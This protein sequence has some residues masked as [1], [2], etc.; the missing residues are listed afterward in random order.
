[1]SQLEE[2]NDDKFTI[3]KC[4]I[5]DDRILTAQGRTIC[6]TS[7]HIRALSQRIDEVVAEMQKLKMEL[8]GE[9]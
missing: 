1:M 8:I 5:C 9:L 3:V 2:E 4:E 6:S 7:C